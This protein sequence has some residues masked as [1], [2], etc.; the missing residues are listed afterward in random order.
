MHCMNMQWY[1]MAMTPFDQG[2]NLW[3][4]REGEGFGYEGSGS[5]V[6]QVGYGGNALVAS[7]VTNG[8][9]SLWCRNASE[10]TAKLF[11]RA[12]GDSDS[13]FAGSSPV[14][15]A[16]LDAGGGWQKLTFDIT[17]PGTGKFY[18]KFAVS[19]GTIQI[20]QMT[21]TPAGGENPEP[22]EADRVEP[23]AV[24][25]TDGAMTISFTG[26]ASFA[27]H[28]LATDSLSPTNWYDFGGTNVGTG[29]P[30]SFAIPIDEEHPQRFFKI[31]VIRKPQ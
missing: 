4:I 28:L 3:T 19:M 25:M 31:E 21:W 29:L 10:G 15:T 23:S 2:S 7:V 11:M 26:D 16:T 6:E 24:S 20:D 9:L 22:T 17:Y 30:Q 14:A 27:Y 5:C 8:T 12:N 1:G 18:I 13:F